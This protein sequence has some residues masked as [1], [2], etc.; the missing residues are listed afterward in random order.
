M[1]TYTFAD[2]EYEFGGSLVGCPLL[3]QLRIRCQVVTELDQAAIGRSATGVING[4]CEECRI[5]LVIR[6]VHIGCHP[7]GSTFL[8]CRGQGVGRFQE[9][10]GSCHKSHSTHR[11]QKLSAAHA[12]VSIHLFKHLDLFHIDSFRLVIDLTS[13]H[14]E[15]DQH[16]SDAQPWV[17]TDRHLGKTSGSSAYLQKQER[18]EFFLVRTIVRYEGTFR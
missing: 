10:R 9:S 7:E 3:S 18:E 13:V 5:H 6:S 14:Q 8:R 1:K 12:T 15:N 4:R 2:L 16:E 17:S 11:R